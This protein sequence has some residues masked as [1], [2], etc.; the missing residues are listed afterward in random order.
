MTYKKHNIALNLFRKIVFLIFFISVGFPAFSQKNDTLYFINGDKVTGEITSFK[1][2]YFTLKTIA[3][4][5]I[6]VKFDKLSTIYSGKTFEIILD[7]RSRIF[8][9]I[10]TS[11]I[12]STVNI[13]IITGRKLKH[14]SSIVEMTPIKNKLWRRFRGNI[15]FGYTYTKSTKISQGSFD[16]ILEY[17]QRD[18]FAKLNASAL[19]STESGLE[20]NKKDNLDITLLRYFKKRWF[21]LGLTGAEQN[22]ELGLDLR[23]KGILGFG[24]DIIHTK[25]N[26]LLGSLGISINQERSTDSTKNTINTEGVIA[27]YYKLFIISIPKIGITSGFT[28]YPSFTVKDRWRVSYNIK[29]STE[30]ISNFIISISMDYNYDSKPASVSSSTNDF[31]FTTSIGYS[32][33]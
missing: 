16:G 15:D 27:L 28:T 25:T 4:S 1:Y 9:S 2:G 13:V 32:F 21:V 6:E 14:L 19:I 30:I 29:V 11:L 31:N 3:M 23:L 22:T 33:Y 12:T 26:Q 5:T 8:G 18:Y 7:D 10:D 17:R 20:T 24:K